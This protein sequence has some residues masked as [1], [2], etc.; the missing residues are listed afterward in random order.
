MTTTADRIA[1]AVILFFVLFLLFFGGRYHR[2]ETVGGAEW[3]GYVDRVEELRGGALP[4]DPYRPLLYTIVAAAAGGIVGDSFAGARIVSTLAAGLFLLFAWRAGRG[5]SGSWAGLFAAS[6]L[7]LNVNVFTLGLSASTDMLFAAFALASVLLAARL[8]ETPSARGAAALGAVVGL[9]CFTRYTGFFLLPVA[10]A[11]LLWPADAGRGGGRAGRTAAF[12]LAGACVLIPHAILSIRVFG[13]PFYSES[14]K[15]LAFKLHGG[16]DWSYFSRMPAGG[17]WAVIS[18]DPAAFLA[19]GAVEIGRF[20]RSTLYYLGGAGPAGA[21]F[22]ALAAAGAARELVRRRHP[23]AILFV[24]VYLPAVC[25]F[26]FSGV[27]FLLPLLPI[28]YL[29]AAGLLDAGWFRRPI[30][31][32]RWTRGALVAAAL[33]VAT[34]V[35]TATRLPAFVRAH[36]TAELAAARKLGEAH[37]PGIVVLGTFPFMQRYVEYRWVEIASPSG[38]DDAGY[39]ERLCRQAR[40]T[41]ADFAVVGR[42]TLGSRPAGLLGGGGAPSCLELISRDGDVSLYRVRGVGE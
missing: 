27:R 31:R 22:A 18:A 10:L 39:G 21:L 9:A 20:F 25:L 5:Q 6:A 8:R 15:N 24:A 26:F 11:A 16:G 37:G 42:L 41:G 1:L 35:S 2:M 12:L 19:G 32:W 4:R 3:D 7:A 29:A 36:P 28:L 23:A 14:W 40:E 13:V 34:A 17:L 33:L 30:G 38:T